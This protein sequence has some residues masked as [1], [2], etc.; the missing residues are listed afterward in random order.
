M[1]SIPSPLDVLDAIRNLLVRIKDFD[2]DDIE[3]DDPGDMAKAAIE[4][5]PLVR[6]AL[7]GLSAPLDK[8]L[9]EGSGPLRKNSGEAS[10]LVWSREKPKVPG[11][12]HHRLP[13]KGSGISEISIRAGEPVWIDDDGSESGFGAGV[14]WA[15]P[16]P[17]PSEGEALPEASQPEGS[18]SPSQPPIHGDPQ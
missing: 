16:I 13:G 5:V 1:T 18:K 3:Y 2:G 17:E 8:D 15:G 10:P 12:Y 14:E 7:A 9:G 6:T 4:L 11:T